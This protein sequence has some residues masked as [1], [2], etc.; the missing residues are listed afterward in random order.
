MQSPLGKA[1]LIHFAF[2]RFRSRSNSSESVGDEV[3][4]VSGEGQDHTYTLMPPKK[5]TKREKRSKSPQSDKSA[6]D[7]AYE[8]E[9][10][11]SDDDDD[12]INDIIEDIG[13]KE[14][15]VESEDQSL[16]DSGFGSMKNFNLK[17]K[18]NSSSRPSKTTKNRGRKKK[19]TPKNQTGCK[20]TRYVKRIPVAKPQRKNKNAAHK[21]AVRIKKNSP[22]TARCK[23]RQEK[24]K[25]SDVDSGKDSPKVDRSGRGRRS[26][27]ILR[28]KGN[29][30]C[31][32][33]RSSG[34][35]LLGQDK[36]EKTKRKRLLSRRSN[37]S[38]DEEIKLAAGSL[39]RLA[40]L[41]SSPASNKR[42]AN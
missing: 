14:E 25:N 7:A 31:Y 23:T 12:V 34:C 28:R 16:F 35:K 32:H 26:N 4:V 33:T 11:L 5:R 30:S 20:S 8:F 2:N 3:L 10:G 27:S 13:V 24:E 29:Q 37:V 38:D 1:I 21:L 17:N 39:M 42:S 36:G 15:V 40:G 22:L 6:P 9:T 18:L 41:L 19:K